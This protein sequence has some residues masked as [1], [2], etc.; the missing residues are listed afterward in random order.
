MQFNIEKKISNF[1]ESQFPQF[2]LEEGERFVAFVKAYY[3]WMESEGQVINH[4][5]ELFNYRDIDN[6]LTD[7]LEHFQKKYLYGIPFQ[8]ILDKRLLLKHIF[9]VYRS[10]GTVQCYKLLFRLIY[11]EDCEIYLPGRDVLRVS[12]G[13]WVQPKYLEVVNTANLEDYVGKVIYGVSSHT[14]AVVESVVK[15]PVNQNIINVMYISNVTPRG[16]QFKPGEKIVVNRDFSPNSINLSTSVIGSLDHL[17]ILNGGQNFKVGDILRI[18]PRDLTTNEVV[19]NGIGGD[20]KVIKTGRGQGALTYYIN[21]P[22]G[23]YVR[24]SNIYIY[25]NEEDLSGRDA[26]F[27][28]GPLTYTKRVT[29]NTDLILDR[30]YETTGALRTLDAVGYEF[31]AD[32]AANLTSTI[33]TVLSFSTNTFGSIASLTKINGGNNY[34]RE[35]YIFIETRMQS[36][37]LPG[38][39]T[40]NTDSKV[41]T[42]TNTFITTYFQN[43][44]PIFLKA[45]TTDANTFE[46][47]II[48]HS[49]L[50][51][52]VA[53]NSTCINISSNTILIANA[54]TI[55]SVN[56]KVYYVVPTDNTAIT[57]LTGNSTYYISF[58]NSSAIALSATSGGANISITDSRTTNPGEIHFLTSDYKVELYAKPYS[59]ATNTA[60]Y[61]YAAAI[62]PSN[63]ALYEPLMYR[64]DSTVNGINADILALPS[65]GNDVVT[66]AVAYNSGRGYLNGEIVDCY[67]FDS[68]NEPFI[69][70][71]GTGY[72]NGDPLLVSGGGAA[73]DATGYVITDNSGVITNITMLTNGSGYVRVPYVSVKSSTGSGAVLSATITG[74]DTY[75]TYSSVKGRIAINGIGV[76]QG[77]WSTTQSFLNSDKYIQDSKFYQDFSY[78]IRTPV[79]LSKYKSIMNDTFHM[80]GSE[81]FGQFQSINI[82]VA[83]PMKILQD[84][85]VTSLTSDVTTIT[86]DSINI[87]SDQN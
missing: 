37:A 76:S 2:Y 34:I 49:P 16:G 53:A 3:E 36:N 13:T 39:V 41:V 25:N 70:D 8:I 9:D 12:D 85:G 65:N 62:F 73:S 44:E 4:S 43:N 78:Q 23:G 75:N 26:S 81:L 66:E 1:I 45:N 54:D 10:K 52:N 84:I 5:R 72:S 29:Y 18:I 67:L 77:Y 56:D 82:E 11:N 30:I 17:E 21:N 28:L 6:T 86:S 7:F 24:D 74:A 33:E 31:P 32:P 19:T 83:S 60:E 59:N 79:I 22:G 40:Y 69:E 20:V 58:T 57:T 63:Y 87:T 64:T 14:E 27:K 38:T 80:A 35:P 48:K 71:G 51:V 42:S 68:L 55:F 47:Q 50:T 15:E 61:Y 46:Q